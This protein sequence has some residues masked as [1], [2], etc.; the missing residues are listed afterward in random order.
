MRNMIKRHYRKAK[1][2]LKDHSA[3]LNQ[4]AEVLIQE[5]TIDGSRIKEIL[6][7]QSGILQPQS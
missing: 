5:E 2:M 4:I 3:V 1:K 7:K 6:E